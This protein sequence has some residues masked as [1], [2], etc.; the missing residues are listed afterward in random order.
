MSI[1]ICGKDIFEDLEKDLEMT[2]LSLNGFTLGKTRIEHGIVL[3]PMAGV[4][5][6]A[7]REICRELGAEMTVSEMISAK[8]LC[9]EQLCKKKNIPDAVKT[10]PLACVLQEELPMA[11]QIFGSEPEYMA[12]AAE[13]IESGEYLGCES[14]AKPTSIDINM[15]CPVAKVVGNGEGSALM[16]NPRLAGEIVSAVVR[17]TTLP[18]TVKMRAGWD[19]N[20]INAPELAKVVEGSGASAICVHGRTRAQ[21]Y[22]PSAD[23]KVIADVKRAVKIPVIGNGDI[24]SVSDAVRMAEETGC[25][26]VMLARGTLGNPWLFTELL[27]AIRGKEYKKPDLRER[28]DVAMRQVRK[29]AEYKGD[30]IAVAE[31]RKHLSWYTKGA[32][33]A[34]A[35]RFEINNAKT[36][37]EMQEIVNRLVVSFENK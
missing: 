12:K 22:A 33:G 32:D 5:D 23:Y 29:M 30:F 31:A 6:R 16:K 14:T 2:R 4:T 26:G 13:L 36:V 7:F 3:A 21:M 11:V 1:L 24:Y 20:S 19:S 18:V 15:G 37:D 17:A 27:C 8:A 9:F 28:L 10:A 35:A 34:A 25:D